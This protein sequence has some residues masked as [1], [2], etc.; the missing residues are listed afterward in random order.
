MNRIIIV[1]ASGHGKVVADIA[2][3]NGYNEILFL[4]DNPSL[5]HCMEYPVVGK[6]DHI[7]ALDGD[8]FVAIG[9]AQIRSKF[10]IANHDRK[11][12]K[13]IHPS[14]IIARNVQIGDGTA[15]MAG[16]V[17]NPDVI[18]GKGC[19][20][21]TASSIDHDCHIGNYVHVAVGA[22]FCGNVEV[23]DYTWI[24]AGTIVSNNLY[25]TERCVIGAG[26]LVIKDITSSGTYYGAPAR[27]IV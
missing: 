11:F 14:A 12:A 9:N 18:I 16:A 4:D 8:L 19:I 7:K 10:M 24:G 1:G 15:I 20:I 2:R 21:N 3:L 27:K 6:T 5:H 22:H 17:I 23:Q 13:L 26:T 25:I